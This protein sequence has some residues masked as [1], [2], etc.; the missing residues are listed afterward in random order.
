[1]TVSTKEGNGSPPAL[2]VSPTTVSLN[3]QCGFT[4]SVVVAGGV[5]PLSVNS[6]HPRVTAVLSGNTVQITRIG[7]G[8]GATVYPNTATVS[9]TDG[10]SIQNV[11]VNSVAINCP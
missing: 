10:T 6:T 3:D 4:T 8:D 2:V 7:S 9:V 11:T 5:G 1:V